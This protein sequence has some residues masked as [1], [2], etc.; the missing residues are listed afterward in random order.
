M[1]I[2]FLDN[3]VNY[4]QVDTN[5][6]SIYFVYDTN[7]PNGANRSTGDVIK[8]FFKEKQVDKVNIFGKPKGTYFPENLV[9]TDELRLLGFR[10]RTDK[11]VRITPSQ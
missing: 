10:I 1:H 7:S 8:L 11:P 5:A 2:K 3:Q 9:N 4:I 6:A